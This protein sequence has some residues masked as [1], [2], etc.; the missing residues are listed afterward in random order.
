VN[1][2]PL[3]L[4]DHVMAQ[5]KAL[6]ADSGT[7]LNQFLGSIVAE[8]IGELRAIAEIERRIARANVEDVRAILAK[9]PDVPPLPGD[10]IL[11]DH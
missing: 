3:R 5:A 8:R 9:V 2:Y 6:A 4:P 10:E 1:N 7:S 11:L